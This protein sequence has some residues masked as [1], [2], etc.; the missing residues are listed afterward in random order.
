MLVLSRRADMMDPMHADR[1]LE[2]ASELHRA[3][4]LA[5]ARLLYQR[6]L[7][8][9]P[10]DVVA[11]FRAGVLELQDGCPDAALDL[12]GQAAAAA[13][14]EAR[15]HLGLGQVFQ[16]LRR[17]DEA[18]AACRRVLHIDPHCADAHFGLGIALQSLHEYDNAIGAYEAAAGL[19]PAYSAAFNNIGNC[20]RLRGRPVEAAAAYGQALDFEPD[21]ADAMS[22]LG[23]LFT[24]MGRLEEAVA[25]LQGAVDRRPSMPYAVN[26]S[27]A[28][29]RQGNFA[30]A[31]AALS[32]TLDRHADNPEAAF[33]LGNARHGLGRLREAADQYRLAI[34]LRPDYA[35]AM[36][37]LGNIHR[38]LGEYTAAE[39]AYESATRVRPGY[40]AA[41]NNLGCLLRARGRFEQAEAMLRRGLQLSPDEPILLDNLG[42]VLKDGGELDAGIDCFRQAV[43]LDPGNAATHSNL[44]YALSFQS[45]HG[46]TTLAEAGRWNER[47]AA[48]LP[49]ASGRHLN[50]RSPGRRLRIGYVSPDF[51]D[52][53]QSL[54]TIP[55]LSRHDHAAFEIFCYASVQRPDAC[56]RRIAA[57]ADVWRDV[58]L[59]DDE[60]LA[61]VVRDDQIDILVDL[62]MH[63]ANGRPLLFARKPAPIQIAWLAYP[64]TTG[65]GAM[66]YRFTD[67]RL[68]PAGFEDHY[69]ERSIRLPDSFWCYDP[70]TD[71]PHVNPLPAIE[72]GHVTFGCLNNPC[73]VTDATLGLW[74][75]VLH[76]LPGSR[77]R[78][79]APPG[80]HRQRVLQ[81]LAAHGIAA[82]RISFV[83]HQIRADYLCSYHDIDIG[84]DTFPYNG[85]TT[86]LDSLWMGVP[87]ITRVGE[88]CVGRAGLSQLFQL[89]LVEFAADTDVAFTAAA[90]ALALDLPRLAEL[91]QR[92]RPRLERSALMDAGRFARHIEAV[93]A[94]V[95]SDYCRAPA[96]P[97]TI[98]GRRPRCRPE[99]AHTA[100]G[101]DS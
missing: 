82:D 45:V 55:L 99:A 18:A 98:A 87:T 41:L 52:H 35:D 79:L 17:Y 23:T 96:A 63:M 53:C 57:Y 5:D 2:T 51:R 74:G 61:A 56:T 97:A 30:A 46:R 89:E 14:E 16:A 31:E 1:S 70:L 24:E 13:P 67:P 11:L 78:L 80:R 69:S 64:G 48:A 44:V 81:R 32:R 47:F 54:F 42:S 62:T 12:I 66:D 86:S 38:E 94:Q 21:N 59:L 15:H 58:R 3:G 27:I 65:M 20:Q 100:R 33:N 36:N 95:W 8:A 84:L 10:D 26:L 88:T 76:A 101:C 4:N 25:L 22:N 68:D 91:R 50:D 39:A 7:S 73:K 49:P 28:L 85:H 34:A 93:Y 9:T 19:Q 43:R 75:G 92:L 72:R 90:V 83:A 77:L 29:H 6:V 71:Q 60:A 37:N 40:V